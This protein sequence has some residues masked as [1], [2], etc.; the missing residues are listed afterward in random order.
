MT[1]ET[2]DDIVT[3]VDEDGQEHSFMVLDI[4]PVNENEYA[5]LV[6]TEDGLINSES[7]EQEAVIFRIDEAEGEQTLTVV[8]DDDEWESVAQAWE[9]MTGIEAE[10]E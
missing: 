6:P 10:E 4:I 2:R 5:I 3:L 7:E 9:E 8:E 1:E